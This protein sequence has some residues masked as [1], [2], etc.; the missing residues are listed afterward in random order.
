MG[1]LSG[2][3]LFRPDAGRSAGLARGRLRRPTLAALAGGLTVG[4]VGTAAGTAAAATPGWEQQAMSVPAAHAVSKGDGVTVAVIDSGIVTDQPVLAGRAEN[5]PDFLHED[6]QNE[7]WYGLHGTAMASDVLDV[8]P[9]AKVLGLRAIRDDEDPKY[10]TWNEAMK[11]GPG[12]GDAIDALRDAIY[13]AV[14]QHVD[15][16]SMSLGDDNSF[17]SYDE[18]DAKAIQ[19]ALSQGVTVVA[20]AGNS[21]DLN[22]IDET[23]NG[24]GENNVG[25]PAAYPGVLTVAATQPGGSRATFSSVHNYVDVAAPG[26]DINS[27]DHSG[28][29]RTPIDGTSPAA[30]L[31]SGTV[32]LLLSKYPKLSPAQVTRVMEQTA[33]HSASYSPLTGY[34]QIDAASAL[35]GAAKVKGTGTMPVGDLGTG[36]HFGPGDDGTPARTEAGID[37]GY[38][39]LA[40]A[41]GVPGLLAIISGI[42]LTVRA[43]KARRSAAAPAF[44]AAY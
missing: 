29:G 14:K 4:L 19:Y 20:S 36:R 42:L 28:N 9:E 12:G 6:D 35:R 31:T 25:Y 11:E 15:V 8:A 18:G 30:A 22:E 16:I 27:A 26:V 40:A 21:G 7:S 17:A 5:G 23:G 34:G 38:L 13:Y 32:A 1:H 2:K 37:S 44:P 3:R 33:S 41:I 24:G 43:R 39:E 10:K